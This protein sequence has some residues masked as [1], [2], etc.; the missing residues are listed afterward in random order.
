MVPPSFRTYDDK[1]DEMKKKMWAAY[2]V[3]FINIRCIRDIWRN[4][5]RSVD[6]TMWT[7]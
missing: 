6:D 1:T 3:E 5:N 7:K 4:E 2:S